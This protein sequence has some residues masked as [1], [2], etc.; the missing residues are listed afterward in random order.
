VRFWELVSVARGERAALE[1][2]LVDP[3]WE[4]YQEW[5][6]HFDRYLYPRDSSVLDAVVPEELCRA[7]F[8][9][10]RV[11]YYVKGR[12]LHK[13]AEDAPAPKGSDVL[14]ALEAYDLIGGMGLEQVH[15]D[16]SVELSP[17]R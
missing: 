11:Q 16:G 8:Q 6:D 2:A 7:V 3:R 15:E 4:T 17:R 12:R 5:F 13:L 1:G 9:R 10:S 14:N